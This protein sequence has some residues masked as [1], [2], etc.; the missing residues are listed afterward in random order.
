VDWTESLL[1]GR[2]RLVI[3]RDKTRIVNLNQPGASLDFL[4][5]TFR[6]ERDLLGRPWR[7]LNVFP[8]KK[9]LARAQERVR[10]LTGPDRG[11]LPITSLISQVN[12][13][14]RSWARYFSHRYSRREFRKLNWFV[15]QRLKHHL[16]R[17]SQRRFRAPKD[18]SLYAHLHTLGL[19]PL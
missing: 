15:L 19:Q 9:A 18:Q 11:W 12:L 14:L 10:E 1:E 2:F 3:N 17:R 16:N 13:W 4:G 7:Y 5:Y 6:Y 8:S